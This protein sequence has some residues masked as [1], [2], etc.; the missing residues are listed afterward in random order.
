MAK[1]PLEHVVVRL[2]KF[3]LQAA[4]EQYVDVALRMDEV[5]IDGDILPLCCVERIPILV[6]RANKEI[7]MQLVDR[8]GF[9]GG[10]FIVLLEGVGVGANQR[11]IT[12]TKRM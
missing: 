6:G 1:V 12:L 2:L 8:N 9:G 5:E 3:R 10:E 11:A 7:L 4:K